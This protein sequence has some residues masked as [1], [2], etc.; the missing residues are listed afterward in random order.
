VAVV[1]ASLAV[2]TGRRLT[3]PMLRRS[4]PGG[5][6]FGVNLAV[7]FDA[8][9]F[10]TVGIA[11]VFAA[12]V[13]VLGLIVGK[14]LF[15]EQITRLAVVCAAGA[16]AGVVLFVVPGFSAT[17][18]TPRGLIGSMV[19]MLIWVGYLLATKRARVGVGTV[20]YLLCMSAVAALSL[21]PFMLLFTNEGLAPPSHGWGW[22]VALA[23]V[24]GCLGH[25][26]M[27][28]AQAHVP[29]STA[30]ILLQGET[31]GAA[32]AGAVF[33]HEPLGL[34]QVVGLL[35]AVAALAAL[36]RSSTTGPALVDPIVEPI[37][38]PEP[39][40]DRAPRT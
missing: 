29:M 25:G 30:S 18:T 6:L 22:L 1:F 28:W 21:I 14:L 12:L 9:R 8:L 16:V 20:E 36:T 2:G 3:W 33:L 24:P 5:M 7:W 13:P 32:L 39:I 34:V 10:T 26:L 17:G 35:L 23:I 37:T 27:A 19:A 4:L 40:A 11:T 15:A 31:V 38:E